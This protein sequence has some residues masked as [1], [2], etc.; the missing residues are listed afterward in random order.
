MMLQDTTTRDIVELFPGQSQN[1][2]YYQVGE[3][4]ADGV[5]ELVAIPQV[6]IGEEPPD[7]M[8]VLGYQPNTPCRVLSGDEVIAADIRLSLA[9]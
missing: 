5:I 7:N 4:T 3:W 9:N 2:C 6:C 8:L 1:P